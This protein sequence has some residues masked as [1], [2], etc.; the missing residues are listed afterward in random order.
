MTDS[1]NFIDELLAE[2]EA[3]EE[4]RQNATLDFVLIEIKKLTQRIEDTF[5]QAEAEKC[6]IDDWALR[7]ASKAQ[8]RIDFL[9]KK[10]EIIIMDRAVKTIDL[11]NGTLKLRKKQDKIEIEDFDVFL[12]NA[13]PAMLNVIPEAVKPDIA[14][15]KSYMKMTGGKLPVGVKLIPGTEEFSYKLKG[16]ENGATDET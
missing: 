10:L 16:N 14:G 13:T 15:I 4:V 12:Q 1:D 5:S 2:V 9:A 8:E 6:L 3:A 11:P 7:R